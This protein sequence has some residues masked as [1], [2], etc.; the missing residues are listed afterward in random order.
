M[1]LD[2]SLQITLGPPCST[3]NPAQRHHQGAATQRLVCLLLQAALQI[4]RRRRREEK[5]RRKSR[6]KWIKTRSRKE[7]KNENEIKE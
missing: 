1:V 2:T 7:G 6:R 3:L 4:T 5:R